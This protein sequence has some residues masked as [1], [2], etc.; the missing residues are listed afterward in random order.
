MK[1]LVLPV[2]EDLVKELKSSDVEVVKEIEEGEV[3]A[4]DF[5]RVVEGGMG[6]SELRVTSLRACEGGSNGGGRCEGA[7]D[8]EDS[9]D[10]QLV[11][12]DG[13]GFEL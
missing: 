7:V 13:D 9:E 3:S 1:D 10:G 4:D 6:E 11:R 5:R 8:V 2:G 12:H